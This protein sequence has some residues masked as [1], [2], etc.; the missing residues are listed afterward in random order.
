VNAQTPLTF[1]AHKAARTTD[2]TTS[3]TAAATLETFAGSHAH[4]CLAV[5]GHYGKAGQSLIAERTGLDRVQVN[6]RLNDLHRHG[7]IAP[8]TETV[9][10]HSG[11]Q[12]RLWVLTPSPTT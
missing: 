12:E 5:I 9:T 3:H 10:S 6:R 4:K 11:R 8:T 2:P 1:P 7:E